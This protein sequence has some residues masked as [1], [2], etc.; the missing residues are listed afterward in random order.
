M[1]SE[2]TAMPPDLQLDTLEAKGLIR[3]AAL[4]PEL[5]YLFRHALVQDAAYESLLKQER[6][7]LH[8]VVGDSLEQ[9]YPERR[10]EL[11]AIL[12]MHLEQ[13]GETERAV[14]YL[15]EAARYAHAR[16]AIV[17]AYQLYS[18]ASSLLP[19]L[20]GDDDA[21]R[22]QRLQIELGRAKA[23]FSF[24]TDDETLAILQPLVAEAHRLGDLRLEAEVR[25]HLAF[26]RQFRGE[27]PASS[28][29]LRDSLARISEIAA[30]LDDPLIAA[31]PQAL[32]GMYQVFSGDMRAG[33]EALR[34]AAP[35]LEQKHDFIASS[36]S[37]VALAVGLARLGDF[38]AAEEA[39]RRATEVAQQGDVIARLDAMIAE[40]TLRS[41]RGELDQA[42]PLALACT[43]LAE[44]SGATACVVA[45]NV[46]LGDAFMRQGRY[47]DAKIAFE[48]SSQIAEVTEQ[49]IFR[50]SIAAYLRAT[51]ASLGD[52]GPQARTFEEAIEEARS[53]GDRWGQ[54]TIVW[55][56]AE[57]ELK[58]EGYS[59]QVE[60]DFA[61]AAAAYERM[62]APPF[63]ARVLR[64]WGEAL[65]AAGRTGEGDE[66][67]RRA[68][69]LFE[70]L[71]LGR[72]AN[73]VRQQL[74]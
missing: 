60:R 54:A 66:K 4:E 5:E 70:E 39:A 24:L 71:G 49:K 21:L 18:R 50:P 59:E 72:E 37:L 44:E 69:A 41:I 12:A 14:A 29:E 7:A 57:T 1:T 35:L 9:L 46:V 64:A 10:S 11:A 17:E 33:I 51:A 20:S 62:E 8:R 28:A 52:F 56:R 47:G 74:G 58:R 16:N 67:L 25:L 42:V 73:E 30:E 43:N 19:V 32:V 61:T 45:S 3:V 31:M 13:A 38:G 26:V 40:S 23:G 48:R 22:R 63:V 34:E 36:F 68:L 65:R 15:V 2:T 53:V 6:R 55:R 27:R